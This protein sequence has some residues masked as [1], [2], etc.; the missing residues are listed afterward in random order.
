MAD[1][2]KDGITIKGLVTL[3]ATV[4][5]LAVLAVGGYKAWEW[6][7]K[8]EKTPPQELVESQKFKDEG[9]DFMWKALPVKDVKIGD[10]SKITAAENVKLED[11]EIFQIKSITYRVPP[12]NYDD[13]SGKWWRVH[14]TVSGIRFKLTDTAVKSKRFKTPESRV[15]VVDPEAADIEPAG[16]EKTFTLTYYCSKSELVEYVGAL[17]TGQTGKTRRGKFGG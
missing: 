6:W 13:V 5:T 7:E 14:H 15:F 4:A 2:K 3:V 11:D 9:L 10:P 1:E 8:K 17:H 12:A 16:V